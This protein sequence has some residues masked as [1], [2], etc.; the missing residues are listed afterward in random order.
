[1]YSVDLTAAALHY[2][3][4]YLSLVVISGLFLAF[5]KME[6]KKKQYYIFVVS[7]ILFVL[8]AFRDR[9]M[10][11]DTSGYISM[12]NRVASY[13]NPFN[14]IRNSITEGG[15][16]LYCWSLSRI[17]RDARILFVVSAA[18]IT[19]SVGRFARKYV[20]NVG[21]FY[22]LLVGM[23]HFDFL[24]SGLRQ[25]M[26]I[27]ILLF[28]FEYLLKRKPLPYYA[29]CIVAILFHN[30]ALIFLLLYPLFSM[31]ILAQNRSLLSNLVLFA[32]A[33]LSGF[34]MDDI[35]LLALRWFPKYYYY[36]GSVLVDG[37]PRLAVF[38]KILVFALLLAVPYFVRKYPADHLVRY[39]AGRQMS[40]L[41]LIVIVIASN[42]VALMRFSSY[43]CMY[44]MMH[45]CN[46]VGRMR[47]RRND[48]TWMTLFTLGA[49]YVY[50]LVLVVLKT[51]E[52][53]TTYPIQLSLWLS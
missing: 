45:Y 11:S 19:C 3:A 24:L 13:S 37:E 34:F 9:E 35:L 28:A 8:M 2:S 48:K 49:F 21:L 53:Q 17:I 42:A 4:L 46:E 16:L 30:S 51:P 50:G 5:G 32:A 23:M 41:N 39:H 44:A 15:F 6:G 22:C 40:L 31:K 47:S 18:F 52:W 1:M 29:L 26:A 10:G 20:D 25:S 43:F 27:S 36:A 12:F 7:A 38:L 14:Y 33:F